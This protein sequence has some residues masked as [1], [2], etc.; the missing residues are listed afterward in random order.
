LLVAWEGPTSKPVPLLVLRTGPD[1]REEMLSTGHPFFASRA[2]RDRI[3]VPLTEDTDWETRELVTDSTRRGL[4][5][6]GRRRPARGRHGSGRAPRGV[7]DIQRG[8]PVPGHRHFGSA[9]SRT[10]TPNATAT[11]ED[12]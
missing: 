9:T 2:G 10:R 7:S 1:E 11:L 3:A 8:R 4:P 12:T 5:A 6:A